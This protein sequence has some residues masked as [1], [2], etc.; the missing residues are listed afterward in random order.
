VNSEDSHEVLVSALACDDAI[1]AGP[2]GAFRSAGAARMV[3]AGERFVRSG[4]PG[5]AACAPAAPS[6]GAA[7]S[8][9]VV[10]ALRALPAEYSSVIMETFYRGR[11]VPE[12]ADVLG[13]S[14]DTVKDRCCGALHALKQ[15]LAERGVTA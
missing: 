7:S 12:T 3:R 4:A 1:A 11:S 9:D 6:S 2:A 13:I 10:A 5:G 15:A 8:T 14:A